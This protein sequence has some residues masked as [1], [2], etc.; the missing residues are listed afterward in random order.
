MEYLD[1][2]RLRYKYAGRENIYNEILSD[3][4]SGFTEI[5]LCAKNGIPI[6]YTH[7]DEIV[8]L[9]REIDKPYQK[10]EV[11]AV[12][13]IV[14]ESYS[15]CTIEGAR[16][17]IADT[18]RLAQGKEPSNRS[19]RMIKNNIRAIKLVLNEDF[20]FDEQGVLKLWRVIADDAADNTEIQGDKYRCDDVVIADAAGNVTFFAPSADK[21]QGMMD[22]LFD[23]IN[24]KSGLD[25]FVKAIVI[26]Y[27]FVYIHPF[28][29]GNGRCAR[30]LMQNYLIKSGLEKFKGI[31]ISSGVLKN[32]SG[33]YNALENSE[34]P[35][36]DI[37]FIIIYYLEI[38]RDALYNACEGF[39]YQERHM[40]MSLRQK[41]V[42]EY[43]RKNKGH[44]IT[45]EIYAK[46]Y[47]TDIETAK[48]ELTA[49]TE[50]GILSAYKNGRIEY[51][52]K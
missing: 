1:Y 49:L 46:H 4:I 28:C 35:Y 21:I 44:L 51:R 3:R 2:K 32:R 22:Q 31:S 23:F 29:D 37:T 25:V 36:N 17:S 45:P 20:V 24:S 27:F 11:D 12:D 9:L 52:A 39:G 10:A 19:E 7:S 8:S 50:A 40:E 16:S 14:D 43:L 38:I 6:V 26:H 41:R 33:Y 47:G 15:T 42:I 13:F 5:P 30:L 48:A 18:V 34:N